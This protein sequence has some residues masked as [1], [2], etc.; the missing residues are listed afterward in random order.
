MS[1]PASREDL[2]TWCKR[3]LGFP[4]IQ[5]NIDEDQLDDC[6]D[7]GFQYFREFHYDGTERYYLKYQL[8]STD[9]TNE[10]IPIPPN[11][12]GVTRVLSPN[13]STNIGNIFD[14]N[15]QL[16]LNDLPMF[17]STSYV[18]YEITQQHLTTLD[19]LFVGMFPIRFNR[20]TSKL[21]LDWDWISR[22]P[23]VTWLIIEG[24]IVVDPD[25]Y[26][27]VYND[28]MLKKLCTAYIKRIWATN[29]KK[30]Q[31]LKLPGGVEMN[32]QLMYEEAM[33]E[34]KEIEDDIRASFSAPPMFIIG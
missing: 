16:R 34:I 28:R 21:Y 15:Y 25:V 30:F 33:A 18:N 7:L 8:T 2:K 14:I 26:N 4:V 24:F 23:G 22:A 20:H 5:I 32:G 29:I 27:D 9:I 3:Q 12:I 13:D 17:T 19:M 31:G 10:Y 6:I 11:V 1:I